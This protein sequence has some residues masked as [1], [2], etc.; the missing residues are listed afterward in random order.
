MRD[1]IFLL[2]CVSSYPAMF[3]ELNLHVIQEY[4]LDGFSDHTGN[5]ITGALAVSHKAKIL[6]VHIRNSYTSKSNPDFFHSINST[7]MGYGANSNLKAY[8]EYANI[9]ARAR[10]SYAPRKPSSGEIKNSTYRVRERH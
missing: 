4:D 2:H 3:E 10:G 8:V 6:E 7:Q 9:A 5:V 1:R